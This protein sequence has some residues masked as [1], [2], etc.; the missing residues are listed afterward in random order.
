MFDLGG[1][2]DTILDF[3]AGSGSEDVINISAYGLGSFEDL[4]LV[5]LVE[6]VSVELSA[7]DSIMLANLLIGNLH[8]DDFIV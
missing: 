8:Q 5:Q 2:S 1:G 3:V 6:G 4:T 7:T